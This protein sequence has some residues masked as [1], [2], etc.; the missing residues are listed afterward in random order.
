M[1]PL[2]VPKPP[3]PPQPPAAP[4]GMGRRTNP[5]NQPRNPLHQWGPRFL[6]RNKLPTPQPDWCTPPPNFVGAH[7]STTEWMIYAAISKLTGD[8][9]DPR[10]PPYVGG[11]NWT[12]QDPLLGGR[13]TK[14]GQVCDFLVHWGGEEV[15]IRL[16]T[17][18]FH[19]QADAAK[20]ADEFFE[21]THADRI[22][23]IYDQAFTADCTLRAAVAAVANA[24]AGRDAPNPAAL[25][26]AQQ[27]R[28]RGGGK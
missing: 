22:I 11:V 20:K 27:V 16:Q 21:K 12:Y 18:Y 2:K 4:K 24:L 25:G 14:G 13:L 26:T 28:R 8:P 1:S 6:R 9:P 17:E 7:T 3:R 15:C 19:I 23:D 10:K 5:G